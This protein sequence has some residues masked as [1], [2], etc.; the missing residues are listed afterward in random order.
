[1]S[2]PQMMRMFGFLPSF[3]TAAATFA[4]CALTAAI[5]ADLSGLSQHPPSPHGVGAAALA[6]GW[7][8]SSESSLPLAAA[9]PTAN[10]TNRVSSGTSLELL[11]MAYLL[12]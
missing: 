8:F 4:L 1:M 9:H 2:S 5:A 12:R 10:P 7:A 11:N 6:G 3:W